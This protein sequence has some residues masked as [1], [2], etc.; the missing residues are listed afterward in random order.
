MHFGGLVHAREHL[1]LRGRRGVCCGGGRDAGG[2]ARASWPGTDFLRPQDLR[3]ML[4]RG[5]PLRRG[6]CRRCLRYGWLDVPRLRGPRPSDVRSRRLL[7]ELARDGTGSVGA[8]TAERWLG[9]KPR[10]VDAAPM[11]A[12]DAR[13]LLSRGSFGLYDGRERLLALQL[14][15]GHQFVGARLL[16]APAHRNARTKLGGFVADWSGVRSLNKN[17]GSEKLWHS[18]EVWS[19]FGS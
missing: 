9:G 12:A 13:L 15:P 1:E 7:A 6:D 17:F 8:R 14:H 10:A 5:R 3:R 4:R 16:V 11:R 19:R 18:A 2:A